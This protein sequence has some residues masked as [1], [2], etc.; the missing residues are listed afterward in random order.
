MAIIDA[1]EH[2]FHTLPTA[3]MLPAWNRAD[4]TSDGANKVAMFCLLA[5]LSTRQY[6]YEFGA[7]AD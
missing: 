1:A 2:T 5:A 3:D 4:L 7:N 6:A